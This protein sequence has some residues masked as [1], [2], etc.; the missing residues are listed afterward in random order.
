MLAYE[1]NAVE[2][3]GAGRGVSYGSLY[4]YDAR[5]PLLIHGSQFR[6]VVDE[7]PVESIDIAA[8]LARALRVA[9]PSSTTGRVLESAFAPDVKGG[10]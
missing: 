4:T 6:A 10:R 1:P 3:Y 9:P 7:T 5:V 2:Q 8:T